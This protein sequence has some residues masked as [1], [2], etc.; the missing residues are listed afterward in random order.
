[1]QLYLPREVSQ[2]VQ[3]MA[4]SV[5]KRCG[6][7]AGIAPPPGNSPIEYVKQL[8]GNIFFVQ[9]GANCDNG[10]PVRCVATERGWSGLLIEPVP[11]IFR[12]L[13]RSYEQYSAIKL[14]NIAVANSGG[15]IPFYYLAEQAK[16]ALDLPEWC[17]GLGSMD[18]EHIV[19]ELPEQFANAVRPFIV[20]GTLPCATLDSIFATHSV[21]RVDL[22]Q[23]DTEGQ[24][25]A[26]L[27]QINFER[28]CPTILIYEHKHLSRPDKDAAW[29]LLQKRGYRL[30]E[31]SADTVAWH[32]A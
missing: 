1:M 7:I 27:Q 21:E 17:D 26:I 15:T 6:P 3:R 19:S 25:Y 23:I 28:Y 24:D 11:H 29:R 18:P 4:R 10:D 9:V 2:F 13:A 20:E 32:R 8:N 5:R 14:A 31:F 30:R 12:Q 16:R 22:L